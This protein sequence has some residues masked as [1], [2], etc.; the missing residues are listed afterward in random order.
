MNIVNLIIEYINS[1]NINIIIKNTQID[2]IETFNSACYELLSW[3]KLERKRE[4][5]I[6]EGRKTTLK[7]LVLNP[8]Y[9]WCNLL[10]L[11][12]NQEETFNEIFE[13]KDNKLNFKDNISDTQKSEIRKTA[14]E[15]Y[16]PEPLT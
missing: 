11:I 15:L 8:D 10:T 6:S 13:I 16:N 14:Y 1:Q 12:T 3:L 7:S 2:N 9:N 5:W 4:I